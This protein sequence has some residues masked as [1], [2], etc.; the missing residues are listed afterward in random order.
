ML[1]REKHEHER[2]VEILMR[3]ANLKRKLLSIY[4]LEDIDKWLHTSCTQLDG[5]RPIDILSDDLGYLEVDVAVDQ[6]IQALS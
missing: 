4:T 6:L 3:V 2:K 1:K 5:H